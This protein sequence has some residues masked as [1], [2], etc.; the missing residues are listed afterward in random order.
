MVNSAEL[1]ERSFLERPPLVQ[2]I[3]FC[4]LAAIA[5]SLIG[6]LKLVE[7]PLGSR[8]VAFHQKVRSH[9]FL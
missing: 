7:F 3:S 1:A 4:F 8:E 6:F 5:V 2:L 9:F